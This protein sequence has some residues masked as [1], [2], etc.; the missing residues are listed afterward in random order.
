MDE[1]R[2]I[3]KNCAGREGIIETLNDEV[4]S[5]NVQE[6]EARDALESVQ[7]KLEADNKSIP[8]VTGCE[9]PDRVLVDLRTGAMS[10]LIGREFFCRAGA[11]SRNDI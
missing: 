2:L 8:G 6:N 9:K 11:H 7:G 4:A 3:F 1:F 5:D 10:E